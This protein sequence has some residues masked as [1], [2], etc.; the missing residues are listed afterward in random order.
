MSKYFRWLELPERKDVYTWEGTT[1]WGNHDL[2][3]IPK[4][5]RTYG[6]LGYFS[7]FLTSTISVTGFTGVS[8]YV[9]GGLS[10]W[11]T[12]G[13]ILVGS[14][15]A[16]LNS[17]LGGQPG[18]DHR[19]GF[20]CHPCLELAWHMGVGKAN[21]PS[22]DYDDSSHVRSS[23]LPVSSV[24]PIVRQCHLR[25]YYIANPHGGRLELTS[26]LRSPVSMDTTEVKQSP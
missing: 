7:Y 26:Q 3:P 1:E 13:A 6:V 18:I 20:V 4:K 25:K 12:V 16:G 15:I 17:F 9:A 22:V 10:A 21:C 14:T 24:H 8:A 23:R 5:E 2:Y 19:L 11:E